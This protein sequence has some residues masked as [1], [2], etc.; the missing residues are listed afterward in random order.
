MRLP[1]ADKPARHNHGADPGCGRTGIGQSHRSL[2]APCSNFTPPRRSKMS[3]PLTALDGAGHG[4][5][6]LQLPP[7]LIVAAREVFAATINTG[8][9]PHDCGTLAATESC[10]VNRGT[11]FPGEFGV[12]TATKRPVDRL[13]C[14]FR[15][16]SAGMP[17]RPEGESIP[18]SRGPC[19]RRLPV[20]ADC[21]PCPPD[22]DLIPI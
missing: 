22:T 5:R 9:R 3:P 19:E 2:L 16:K 10:S 17:V 11:G 20:L 7:C 18:F 6:P 12:A 15:R 1:C 8:V 13:G 21:P 4:R 14:G